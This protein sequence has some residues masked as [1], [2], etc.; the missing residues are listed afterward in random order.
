[1]EKQRIAIAVV[2][3]CLLLSLSQA[4]ALPR[5]IE[6]PGEKAVV[7]DPKTHTWG[8]Y[9]AQGRL[10]RSG[11]ASGGKD[12]CKDMH[13]QC[14]TEEGRFRILSLGNASCTS[15]SFPIPTGGSP[16][17]YC[18]YFN[19]A[20]ALHGSPHVVDGNISHGCVRMRVADAKW[21]RYNFADVGTL[22]V[23]LPY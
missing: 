15:P 13:R 4:N 8:A 2:S 6:A 23:I 9:D 17:P 16:M 7:F 20:Q 14:H 12:Y 22:V 1:M 19:E 10:I 18:M 3:V 21:L 5:L 11:L